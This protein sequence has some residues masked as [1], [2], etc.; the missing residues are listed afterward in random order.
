[1][2][3]IKKG[4]FL[5]GII[6]ILNL[7]WEYSHAQLYISDLLVNNYNHTLIRA[8]IIDVLL[9]S[10]IFLIISLKNKGIKWIDKPNP[11][12][13]F[14]IILTGIIIAVIIELN[15]FLNDKWGYKEI[16]PTVFGIGVSPLVQLFTTGII[17]L[18]IIRNLKSI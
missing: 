11:T 14:F 6:L 8:S 13:Y 1:M 16:M 3:N 18:I 2:K 7:I 4:I 12:D 10:F 15:A 5:A 17:S 9:V